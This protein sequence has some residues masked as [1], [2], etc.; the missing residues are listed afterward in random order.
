MTP[1]PP[2]ERRVQ[3]TDIGQIACAYST[4]DARQVIVLIRG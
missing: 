2:T 4:L 1:A 3:T